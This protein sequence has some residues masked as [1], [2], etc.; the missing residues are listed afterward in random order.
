MSL[1]VAPGTPRWSITRLPNFDESRT[2]ESVPGDQLDAASFAERVRAGRPFKIAGAVKHWPAYERWRDPAYL[3]ERVGPESR[4][5]MLEAPQVELL[6]LVLGDQ[7]QA[8]IERELYER[9]HRTVTFREFVDTFE[10]R[11]DQRVLYLYALP[12]EGKS[13]FTPLAGDVTGFPF[14][15]PVNR[16]RFYPLWRAFF[17]RGYTDWHYHP[18][19]E[20]IMCQVTGTKR[21]ALLSPSWSDWAKMKRVATTCM[22]RFDVNT[23]RYPEFGTIQPMVVTVEPGDALFIPVYWWHCVESLTSE[24]G[25]TVALSFDAEPA[26]TWNV[27]SPASFRTARAALSALSLP[28]LLSEMRNIAS[29]A[30]RR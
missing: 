1:S 5:S 4:V 29:S 15:Q 18:A 11:P 8:D 16:H 10:A 19:Q 17:G 14:V 30:I 13:V 27:R 22:Y 12:L 21:V 26:K 23:E 24:L 9:N 2:V 7:T 6:G 3:L 25:A 20:A 28:Q